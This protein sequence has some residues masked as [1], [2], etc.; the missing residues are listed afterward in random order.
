MKKKVW[1]LNHY[2]ATMLEQ[3]GGRHYWM[4]KELLKKGYHPIIFCAD[5]VHNSE[6]SIEIND[7]Y[8]IQEQ[9]GI[10]F[11]IVKTSPYV[12]NGMSRIK[13]IL[14]FYRN[15]KKVAVQYAKEKGNPDIIL[16]S[17]VHPLTCVAGIQLGKK[18]KCSCIAE[19]RDL[20]PKELIDMGTLTEQHLVSKVLYKLEKWIYTKADAVVFTM[21]GGK[22][23]IRDHKWDVQ[24]G[25]NIDLNKIYYINNGVD[26]SA[27]EENAIKY[28]FTDGDLDNVEKFNFVYTGS[29]RRTNQIDTLLDAAKELQDKNIQ[30][31]LWGAGDYVE[32]IQKR[33]ESEKITNVKYKGVVKKSQVPGILQKSD[34]N[35]IHW[36]DM[37]TLKYGCSYNKMFEYL[38]AGR[39]I[40][41][42]VHVGYSIIKNEQCGIEASGRTPKDF[43][44]D[45][46][47]I[48]RMSEDA[49]KK[50][51]DNARKTAKQFDFSVLTDKL[52]Q[53]IVI[54]TEKKGK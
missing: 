1:I 8:G 48:C 14:S 26:V 15:V 33:I 29:I 35:I 25:G 6:K 10:T 21:E 43:A 9:D 13:N 40:Y 5:V 37:D 44:K 41:S 51:G 22:Q 34:V 42:T 50:Y 30:I 18:M 47:D 28:P 23:Y 49:R 24:N 52:I 4:A 45:M 39:P 12:G 11:V 27:F 38:A 36:N 19:I 17:S 3:K 2:A 46:T 54:L 16:A 53:I 20:W 32:T 7:R 31:L